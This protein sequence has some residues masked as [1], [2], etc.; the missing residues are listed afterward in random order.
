MLLLVIAKQPWVRHTVDK[1]LKGADGVRLADFNGDGL[2]DIHDKK[3]QEGRR[4]RPVNCFRWTERIPERFELEG[5]FSK[6]VVAELGG[7]QSSTD[8]GALLPREVD[9][10]LRLT[11]RLAA[12]GG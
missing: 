1:S 9:R 11:E 4:R 6:Q 10:R 2:L 7:E 3:S 8:G 5:H 12:R